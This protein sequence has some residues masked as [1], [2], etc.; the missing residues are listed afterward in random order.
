[1]CRRLPGAGGA[2][3]ALSP[4]EEEVARRIEADSE[5][6]RQAL[7]TLVRANLRL[8]AAVARKYRNFGLPALD[9]IQEGNIGLIRAIQRFDPRRGVRFSTYAVWW[10]QHAIMQVLARQAGPVRVPVYAYAKRVR[11]Q[12]AARRL[13]RTLGRAPTGTELAESLGLSISEMSVAGSVSSEVVP[14]EEAEST[15]ASSVLVRPVGSPLDSCL[16]RDSEQ[17]VSR[18]M[19][20]LPPRYQ[21]I[22]RL[23]FGLDGGR[24]SS[25]AEIGRQMALTRERVRQIRDEALQR[26]R[27]RVLF[28]QTRR[29]GHAGAHLA[30]MPRPRPSEE[31][32]PPVRGGRKRRTGKPAIPTREAA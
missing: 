5:R 11:A 18:L 19:R 10:V 1:V 3:E 4:H 2:Q 14:W 9:L 22:L 6:T 16:Q 21:Q 7:Q 29:N 31:P 32:D 20:G 27:R 25:L 15:G 28:E 24:E 12:Q 23:Q 30:L 17:Q 26:M 8:V 13:E